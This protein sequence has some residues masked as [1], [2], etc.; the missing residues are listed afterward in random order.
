MFTARNRA[1]RKE[2]AAGVHLPYLLQFDDHT[3]QTRKGELIQ[4]IRLDGLPFESVKP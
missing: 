3:L 2:V 1:A 4:V